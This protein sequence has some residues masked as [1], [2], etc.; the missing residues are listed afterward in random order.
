M[1]IAFR[2]LALALMAGVM[3]IGPALA[4]HTWYQVNYTYGV[5]DT[6]E[7]S[8]EQTYERFNSPLGR[9]YGMTVEPIKK[10]DVTKDRYGNI[11]VE[12]HGTKNSE[13]VRMN[14]FTSYQVCLNFLTDNN[15]PW[16]GKPNP[17]DIN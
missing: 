3:M 13:P 17:K 4:D 6:S 9:D 1:T 10:E 15:V 16:I 11:S 8:P 12:L 2:K 5:C 7:W 14:F